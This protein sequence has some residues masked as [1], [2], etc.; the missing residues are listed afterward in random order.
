MG[1]IS[2]LFKQSILNLKFVHFLV[3]FVA[4]YPLIYYSAIDYLCYAKNWNMSKVITGFSKL[5][6]SEKID[7]LAENYFQDKKKRN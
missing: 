6:K 7:W 5:S 3:I 1:E 2:D 4:E